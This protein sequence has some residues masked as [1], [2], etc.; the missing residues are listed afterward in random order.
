MG[1]WLKNHLNESDHTKNVWLDIVGYDQSTFQE[2]AAALGMEA[3]ML[4]ETLLF[5]CD[6]ACRVLVFASLFYLVYDACERLS[7]LCFSFHT[8]SDLLCAVL[9]S[10]MCLPLHTRMKTT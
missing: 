10:S 2:L 4:T 5:K 1:Q 8:H 6:H 7:W 3:D 9:V